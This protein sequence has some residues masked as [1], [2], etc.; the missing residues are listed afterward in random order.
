VASFP[1]AGNNEEQIMN[2][3]SGKGLSRRHL[4]ATS[5]AL[6]V[7]G[8]AMPSLAQQY[9]G[10]IAQ[11]ESVAPAARA[12]RNVQSFRSARW[13]DHFDHLRNGAILCDTDSRVLHYWSED[14][15]T[16]LHYPTSVPMAEEFTRRG[17]TEIVLMRR[18]P[19]WIPTANMRDRDPSLPTRV[20]AGPDNPMGTRAMNLTWQY[21]RIHGIDNPAKIGRKASNG[22]IGLYN[23]NVEELFE[24]ARV[25]T[26]VVVV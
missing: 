1:G 25:G 16:Y 24:L 23:E 2:R 17:R 12:R 19:V 13:Q 14:G 3:H 18:D 4:L 11:D 20:E 15:A 8:L 26:Q 5:G 7:S 10:E 6:V 21:Y 9:T 22:C